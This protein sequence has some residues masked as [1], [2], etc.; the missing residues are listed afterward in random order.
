[1]MIIEL[2]NL[3]QQNNKEIFSELRDCIYLNPDINTEI[4]D[5]KISS[6]KNPLL[7]DTIKTLDVIK[8]DNI[9]SF[10]SYVKYDHFLIFKF[11]KNY[12]FCDTELVPSLGKYSMVKISDYNIYLRKDKINKISNS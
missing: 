12:Y 9:E 3:K 4:K 6:L 11:E 5:V 8:L 10:L 7:I 1:M 2:M